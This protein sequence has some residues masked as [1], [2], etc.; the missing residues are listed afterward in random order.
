[1]LERG[2]LLNT[3]NDTR[4][5]ME[6]TL[7]NA[8]YLF[9]ALSGLLVAAFGLYLFWFFIIVGLNSFGLDLEGLKS[10]L[11]SAYS[12]GVFVGV[13]LVLL[14]AALMV[15]AGSMLL[16]AKYSRTKYRLA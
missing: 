13:P 11:P 8:L 1:M 16:R 10:Q 3:Q 5:T 7:V 14:G 6:Q 15:F 12:Y 2:P 9:C 4:P